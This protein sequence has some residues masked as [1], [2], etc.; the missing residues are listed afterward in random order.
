MYIFKINRNEPSSMLK[1]KKILAKG[2]YSQVNFLIIFSEI[3]L[4]V[5]VSSKKIIFKWND[6]TRKF[7]AFYNRLECYV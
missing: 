6:E 2:T 4:Y 3:L 5:F 1:W 7:L